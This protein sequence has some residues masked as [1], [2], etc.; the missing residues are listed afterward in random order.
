MMI[1]I[2]VHNS[3]GIR[4]VFDAPKRVKKRLRE[5]GIEDDTS[6]SKTWGQS[7]IIQTWKSNQIEHE[8]SFYPKEFME[9][10]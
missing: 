3:L 4:G 1:Y 9:N 8:E 2:V 7:T 10:F 5:L 6:T